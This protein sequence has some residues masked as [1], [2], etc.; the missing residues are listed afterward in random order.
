[1]M[2]LDRILNDRNLVQSRGLV[3]IVATFDRTNRIENEVNVW[4]FFDCLSHRVESGNI[5]LTELR[6]RN[7]ETQ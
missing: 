3:I 6:C 1:M 2:S 5:G 4:W 7:A